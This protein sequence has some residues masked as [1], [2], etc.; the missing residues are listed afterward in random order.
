MHMDVF[1]T[2]VVTA[3]L[4]SLSPGSGCVLSLSN[5]VQYGFRRALLAILGLQCGM[6]LYLLLVGLGLGRVV[7][8][9]P[10]IFSMIKWGGAAYLIWLGW[11]KWQSTPFVWQRY[12]RQRVSL[13]HL[14]WEGVVVNLTNPKTVVFLVALLPQFLNPSESYTHQMMV[15]AMITLV[16]D[17]LVM[18]GYVL[19]AARLS[20]YATEPTMFAW[21]NR[22]F[23]ALFMACGVLLAASRL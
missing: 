15:L 20:R 21:V 5:G 9:S 18:V 19:L 6:A 14:F 8:E 10:E 1:V 3:F 22:L 17:A 7:T 2:Y 12:S 4:F 23:G 11:R 16:V 13:W